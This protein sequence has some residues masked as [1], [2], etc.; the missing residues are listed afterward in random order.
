M[1]V[2]AYDNTLNKQQIKGIKSLQ[3]NKDIVVF[4]TDKT[5]TFT[6]DS[7]NNYKEASEIHTTEDIIIT[8]EEHQKA[9]KIANAHSTLWTR[10]TN[11]GQNAESKAAPERIKANM[12]VE[13]NGY[14]P[15]YALLKDHKPCEDEIRGPKTRLVCSG[16]SANSRKL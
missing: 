8:E 7:P 4:T 11:A 15:L 13:N 3:K 12:M 9:Q 6:A 14:A 16:S 5:G 2:L 1:Y 10:I